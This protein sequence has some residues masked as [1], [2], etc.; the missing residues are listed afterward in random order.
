MRK[1]KGLKGRGEK[2]LENWTW[3]ERKMRWCLEEIAREEERGGV[4][5]GY[6]KTRTEKQWWT[7][8]EDEKVLRDSKG[9]VKGIKRGNGG[10]G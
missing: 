7:W 6:G 9:N 8:D 1:K 5:I 4:W 10:W 3:K 2:L